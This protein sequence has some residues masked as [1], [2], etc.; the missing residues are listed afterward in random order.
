MRVRYLVVPLQSTT[1]V[2]P[3][4]SCLPST[5]GLVFA[6]RFALANDQILCLPP[7]VNQSNGTF[8]EMFCQFHVYL[9]PLINLME[10]SIKRSV[11]PPFRKH[12]WRHLLVPSYK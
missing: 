2:S 11:K 9:L 3:R 4:R 5:D 6:H 12:G 10:H 7:T 8:Y 1:I